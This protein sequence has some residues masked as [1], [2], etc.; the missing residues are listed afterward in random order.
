MEVDME[1][2]KK[3]TILFTPDLH[4]RLA[5][6]AAL[7]G[8]S[9]GAL[10]REACEEHYGLRPTEDRLTAVDDLEAMELPVGT[11]EELE[12]QAVPEP[13]DLLP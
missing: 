4:E 6:L 1:L 10:V 8:V 2:S 13:D 7:R 5:R 3:T 9:L 12:R 11:P